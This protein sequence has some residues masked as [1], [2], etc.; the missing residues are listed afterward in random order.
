MRFW[1]TGGFGSA[2]AAWRTGKAAAARA[3][4][5]ASPTPARFDT[6]RSMTA[7]LEQTAVDYEQIRYE[8]ADGVATI[9]LNRPEQLERVH[10]R[11]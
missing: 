2:P 4:N 10:R 7:R 1:H 9:T 6:D 11:G 8:V 5:T 3:T